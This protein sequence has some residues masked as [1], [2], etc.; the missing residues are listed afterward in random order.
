MPVKQPLGRQYFTWLRVEYT[1]LGTERGVN[2]DLDAAPGQNLLRLGHPILVPG[3][4]LHAD[5]LM[6]RVVI[7]QG[8]R[9]A[10]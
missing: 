2:G 7:P 3:S 6:E 1:N 10:N 4:T 5:V 9:E 8:A